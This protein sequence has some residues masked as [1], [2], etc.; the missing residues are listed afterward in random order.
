MS[1]HIARPVGGTAVCCRRHSPRKRSTTPSRRGRDHFGVRPFRLELACEPPRRAERRPSNHVVD[2]SLPQAPPLARA[3]R[4]E[5]NAASTSTQ[6]YGLTKPLMAG[7]RM[8]L[9]GCEWG[10]LTGGDRARSRPAKACRCPKWT[11]SPLDGGRTNGPVP[12]D[13][14]RWGKSIDCA[15]TRFMKGITKNARAPNED[16]SPRRLFPPPATFAK[17]HPD[18]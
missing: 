16:L 9:Q 3:R 2:G 5:T 8:H 18:Y 11:I 14:A 12:M 10:A 4:V 6:V 13:G 17:Q 15:A 7:D 1:G